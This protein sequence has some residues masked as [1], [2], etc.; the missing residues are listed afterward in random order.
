AVAMLTAFLVLVF[1][2]APAQA[3]AKAAKTD[4]SGEFVQAAIV[5]TSYDPST[6]AA[7]AV[8]IATVNGDW[9]GYWYEEVQ[10]IVDPTGDTVGTS[11]QVFTGTASDGT[12]GTLTVEETFTVTADH[13]VHA[14]GRIVDGTGDWAGSS[15]YYWADGFNAA[16]G[17]GYWHARWIRPNR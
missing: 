9:T 7:T 3:G 2:D 11:H 1:L 12:S 13:Q 16:E 8:G 14:E 15:G 5:P 17:F 4:V 10:A 6:G